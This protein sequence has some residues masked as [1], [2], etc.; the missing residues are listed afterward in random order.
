MKSNIKLLATV[1]CV[2]LIAGCT[3]GAGGESSQANSSTPTASV[4]AISSTPTS[5]TPSAPEESKPVGEP[6]FLIG[7]DGKAILTSEITRLENTDKTAETLTT[8][9]LGAEVYCEGFT[10]V[11]EPSGVCYSMYKNPEMFEN[12]FIGEAPENNNEWKRVNVGDE[13]CGLKVKSA[14]A[15]FEVK[16]WEERKFPGRYYSHM[17]NNRCEFDGTV[18]LEGYLQVT[19][20]SVQYTISSELLIF[21]P[22]ESKLPLMPAYKVDNEK[23]FQTVFQTHCV[24]DNLDILYVSECED[25]TLGYFNDAPCDLDGLGVGDVAYARVTLGNITLLNSGFDAT[26]EKVELLSDI[27]AHNEDITEIHQPAPV[28]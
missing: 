16:D 20:R 22:C 26:L 7:L 27:L 9:D 23:G 28:L 8:D 2:S 19:S 10:Y 15:F 25:V 6:T 21:Y 13:I 12:T 5:E 1:L 11:K 17:Y 14:T 4:P 3:E 18:E 24:Y